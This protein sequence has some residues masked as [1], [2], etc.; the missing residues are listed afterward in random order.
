MKIKKKGFTLVELVIVIAVVAVLMAVLIP[1]FASVIDSAQKSADQQLVANMN[2]ALAE[3]RIDSDY[4]TPDNLR[5][6][7][8]ENG[9]G[10][11]KLK[12][13]NSVI[14]YDTETKQLGVYDVDDLIETRLLKVATEPIEDGEGYLTYDDSGLPYYAEEIFDGLIIVSITGTPLA[15]ALYDLHN[16]S[17][18]IDEDS[19]KKNNSW[20]TSKYEER[21]AQEVEEPI[22]DALNKLSDD[23]I[24]DSIRAI[25]VHTYFVSF[26]YFQD[27]RKGGSTSSKVDECVVYSIKFTVEG[28]VKVE[29]VRS[30]DEISELA[31][32]HTRIVFNERLEEYRTKYNYDSFRLDNFVVPNVPLQIIVPNNIYIDSVYSEEMRENMALNTPN[33]GG[34]IGDYLGVPGN[35][36]F[37]VEKIKYWIKN[38][39]AEIVSKDHFYPADYD[40][41]G[42]L[43]KLK[44]AIADAETSYNEKRYGTSVVLTQNYTINGELEIPKGVTLEIPYGTGTLTD[45][46]AIEA[47]DQF[48]LAPLGNA[49][50][51]I[52]KYR[53]GDNNMYYLCGEGPGSITNGNLIADKT[54]A[55]GS[56]QSTTLTIDGGTLTIYG[57]VRVG[58]VIGYPDENSY[59]GHTS[60]AYGQIT[61]NGSIVVERNG[62]LDV[63]GFVKGTG[64]VEAKAGSTVDEPFVITDYYGTLATIMLHPFVDV[65]TLWDIFTAL[66]GGGSLDLSGGLGISALGTIMEPIASAMAVKFGLSPERAGELLSY[67]LFGA[68]IDELMDEYGLTEKQLAPLL[69]LME[70]VANG[71]SDGM[72]GALINFAMYVFDIS[73]GKDARYNSPFSRFGVM[74]IQNEFTI[75]YGAELIGRANLWVDLNPITKMLI[76]ATNEKAT[77]FARANAPLVSYDSENAGIKLTKGS[78]LVCTYHDDISVDIANGG[79]NYELSPTNAASV[80]GKIGKTTVDIYGTVTTGGIAM[81]ILSGFISSNTSSSAG[82]TTQM[83]VGMVGPFAS[84]VDTSVCILPISYLFDFT[85][86]SGGSLIIDNKTKVAIMPGSTLTVES[87]ATL[88]VQNGSELYVLDAMYATNDILANVEGM[89][90][91]LVIKYYPSATLLQN[92]GLSGS[93]TFIVNGT[94]NVNRGSYIGG[95]VQSTSTSA[96]IKVAS[97]ANTEGKFSLG[98]EIDTNMNYALGRMLALQLG[99]P[100]DC[101]IFTTTYEYPLRVVVAD[102]SGGYKLQVIKPGETYKMKGTNDVERSKLGIKTSF[103]YSYNLGQIPGMDLWYID[104]DG[105]GIPE[106][107]YDLQ[108]VQGLDTP[109]NQFADGN[110]DNW[111]V[112]ENGVVTW[113]FDFSGNGKPDFKCVDIN[114]DSA[115]WYVD[116]VFY[117]PEP[118][119]AKFECWKN[120]DGIWYVDYDCDGI[121]DVSFI[122]YLVG[123]GLIDEGMLEQ[124]PEGYPLSPSDLM[125]IPERYSDEELAAFL[126]ALSQH[127][128]VNLDM[129]VMVSGLWEKV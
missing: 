109:F 50:L 3:V 20:S 41:E 27:G 37:P 36:I 113:Y 58:G 72:F 83:L 111:F 10:D 32:S 54:I 77:M 85:V 96:I 44:A 84:P 43:A 53:D 61:N 4:E 88:T 17:A 31:N 98:G 28:N 66:T 13:E 93:G 76:N 67:A 117:L 30:T 11:M 40:V 26:Q 74:N 114:G 73:Q 7:L 51:A 46:E 47:K 120:E 91:P 6:L 64:T 108:L 124:L 115:H 127:A 62:E 82:G 94:L 105:D 42:D 56:K 12:E 52:D 1:T 79:E 99:Q 119:P 16:L 87:E 39:L 63:W 45:K 128:T 49:Y 25:M 2:R 126:E 103:N 86:K 122:E 80:D 55:D 57:K 102:G 18:M 121:L 14:A 92:N 23:N 101:N 90:L 112:E 116:A 97:G 95:I 69:P 48:T 81:D 125:G 106:W 29:E 34:N 15:E 60:G 68:D 70:S 123:S 65:S 21:L 89:G 118:V 8:S 19:V 104:I 5:A 22:N 78:Y 59:Q 71:E 35:K 33:F 24:C 107:C 75:R 129:S 110:P 38:G 100:V 9:F